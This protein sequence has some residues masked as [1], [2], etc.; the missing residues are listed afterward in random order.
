[1]R[2]EVIRYNSAKE[3]T[4]SLFLINGSYQCEGLEDQF[5]NVKIH[6]ETRI[7]DGDYQ[8]ELRAEGGFHNRYLKKYGPEFHKGMIQISKVLGFKYV[9]IHPGNS[10]KDT[11][12]CYL[13]GYSDGK[14]KNWISESV[15]AYKKIYTPIVLA[16]LD[17]ECVT[18]E[19]K[20]IDKII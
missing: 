17:G 7:P 4:N 18:I 15:S 11:D 12:A 8:I 1:M 2:I 20:T 14:G 6:G 13:P 16:L 5:N 9:L 3:H 19:F 10:D